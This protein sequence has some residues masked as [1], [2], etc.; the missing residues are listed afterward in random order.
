LRSCRPPSWL[1]PLVLLLP[2]R[3]QQLRMLARCV[4]HHTAR[5]QGLQAGKPASPAGA[6]PVAVPPPLLLRRG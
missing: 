6:A 5:G 2:L 4:L 1:P 3:L